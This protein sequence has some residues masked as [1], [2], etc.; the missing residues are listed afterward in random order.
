MKNIYAIHGAFSSPMIFNY[1]Q[2]KLGNNYTWNFLDY[3]KETGGLRD[4]IARVAQFTEPHHVVGH[5]MGG[6][7]ALAL[8]NQ[9]WVQSVTT[10]STPL[11]GTEINI[12]Q[13]YLSRSEFMT[14]ISSSGDFI[15]GLYKSEPSKPVQHLIS[16]QGFNPWIYEPSDGV[17]TL[18]SQRAYTLGHSH[19]IASNH[20]EIMMNDLTVTLLKKFW[21]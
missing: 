16:T 19:D 8:I 17:V 1:I 9:P 4:I 7:M 18:R 14:D 6:L 11:G 2:H 10:I 3:Q 21:I 13:Q 12:M 20:A 5:S 15:R